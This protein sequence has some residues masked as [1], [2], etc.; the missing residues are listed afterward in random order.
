MRV[1]RNSDVVRDAASSGGVG[2]STFYE[3]F[4]NKDDVLV[5]VIDPVFIPLAAAASGRGGRAALRAMLEHVWP[6]RALAR[7]LFAPP[8]LAKLQRKLAG[9]IEARLSESGDGPPLALVAMGAAAGQLAMRKMWLTGEA[10]CSAEA[11]AE[12]LHETCQTNVDF[13]R[14][15]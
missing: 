3:H 12:H 14:G 6:Q 5:A 2:R 1:N 7:V 10:S 15:I 13:P 4:R 8:V 9:M 11:F